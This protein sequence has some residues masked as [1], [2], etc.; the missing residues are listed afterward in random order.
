MLP[1]IAFVFAQDAPKCVCG[2]SSQRNPLSGRAYS[3]PP[4]R[5]LDFKGLLRSKAKKEGDCL[6][7][8]WAI[9]GRDAYRLIIL[10]LL[11][12]CCCYQSVEYN[13]FEVFW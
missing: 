10:F 11:M 7:L 4:D 13:D 6:E 8:M 2:R 12:N 9:E 1:S 3:A 5:L